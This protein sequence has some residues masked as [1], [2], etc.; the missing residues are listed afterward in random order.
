MGFGMIWFVPADEAANAVKICTE[1]GIHAAVCGKV[2]AG[3]RT[4]TVN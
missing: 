3:N 1:S 4:V 2:T